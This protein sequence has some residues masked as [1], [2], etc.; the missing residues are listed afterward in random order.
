MEDVA[1]KSLKAPLVTVISPSAKSVVA[2]L[3]VKVSES[4][5]SLDVNPSAP[6][7]TVIV[8]VGA[9]TSYVQLNWSAVELLLP[10]SSVQT[11]AGI[12]IVPAPSTVGVTLKVY[13]VPEPEKLLIVPFPI[14][15]SE[16][17]NPVTDSSNVMVIGMGDVL[18]EVDA[19]EVIIGI[20]GV[21][22]VLIK[23]KSACPAPAEYVEP[24]MINPPSFVS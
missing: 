5:A 13:V 20:G 10:A 1:A 17:S 16:D 23:Y 4:V 15:T 12:S 24:A 2:S 11:P 19:V 3:L 18:V 21:G 6:S 14:V 7:A 22:Y 9:V 8:M